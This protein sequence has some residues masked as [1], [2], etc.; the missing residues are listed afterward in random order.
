MKNDYWPKTVEAQDVVKALVG[1]T[2]LARNGELATESNVTELKEISELVLKRVVTSRYQK[3][4]LPSEIGR[5]DELMKNDK[6]SYDINGA[7]VADRLGKTIGKSH[8]EMLQKL[9]TLDDSERLQLEQFNRW[10]TSV[11]PLIEGKLKQWDILSEYDVGQAELV[12]RERFWKGLRD[13]KNPNDL[14]TRRK[15]RLYIC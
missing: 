15:E 2:T 7:S 13:G 5:E 11:T 6:Y 8:I 1:I 10:F 4:W 3:F 9:L 14:L 12:I